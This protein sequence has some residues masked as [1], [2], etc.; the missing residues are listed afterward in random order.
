MFRRFLIGSLLLSLLVCG[1]ADLLARRKLDERRRE[2]AAKQKE[3]LS[4]GPI[5]D[6]VRA[7]QDQ[8]S[9]LQVR[10]DAINQLKQNQTGPYGAMK[11]I[12]AL[13][14]DSAPIDS[15]AIADPHTVI[16]LGHAK[17]PGD[18]DRL[19]TYF[20]KSARRTA[21]DGAFELRGTVP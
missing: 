8:K 10:I 14:S 7:Y 21:V 19:A 11:A 5:V 1:A 15:I 2:L 13:G 12:A 16:I 20:P 6:E 4:L 17:S 3:L 9:K 18:V